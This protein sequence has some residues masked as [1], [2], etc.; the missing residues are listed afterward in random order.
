MKNSYCRKKKYAFSIPDHIIF[1]CFRADCVPDMVVKVLENIKPIIRKEDILHVLSKLKSYP[2]LESYLEKHT[3]DGLYL[4][5]FRKCEDETCCQR[6]D[7][8]YLIMYLLQFCSQMMS[9]MWS[10][11]IYTANWSHG[12][13]LPISYG[14][15]KQLLQTSRIQ[16]S[17][18][19]CS[20]NHE[21]LLMQQNMLRL[22]NVVFVRSYRCTI[23]G[24][25][26]LFA[27]C[28]T[29]IKNLIHFSRD[30]LKK[31]SWNNILQRKVQSQAGLCTLWSWRYWCSIIEEEAYK[32]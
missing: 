18:Q 24:R 3:K 9:N 14:Q 30:N 23:F 16:I 31:F 22:L 12:K 2:N 29:S 27:R 10:F 15:W 8:I 1:I 17:S 5:Q 7:Q 11:K 32:V 13:T 19:S 21:V 25:F 4:L 6:I 20:S 26:H 28:L